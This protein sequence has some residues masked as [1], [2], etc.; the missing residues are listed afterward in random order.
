MSSIASTDI[1]SIVSDLIAS[2]ARRSYEH[3]DQGVAAVIAVEHDVRFFTPTLEAVLGQRVVPGTIVVADCTGGTTQPVRSSFSVRQSGLGPQGGDAVAR[4]DVQLV[5]TTGSRSFAD[6]LDRAMRYASLDEKVKALWLLHD[7]SRPVDDGCLERLVETWHNTPTASIL[8]T[9]QLDWSGRNLHNVGYYAGRHEL[10]SLVVEGEPDQEQYDMRN[11]VYAVSLAGA[12]VPLKTLSQIGGV[13]PWFGSMGEAGDLC[14][15][16]CLDGG[17]VVVVPR[18]AVAHRRARVEGLRSR[19]GKP[20]DE[21]NP[22][23]ATMERYKSATRFAYTDVAAPLWPLMWLVHLVTAVVGAVRELFAKHPYGAWCSLCM[24]WYLLSAV[25]PAL[26]ARSMVASHSKVPKSRLET[27]LADHAQISQWRRR[28]AAFESQRNAVLLSPLASWHLR[29]MSVKR[30][31]GALIMAVVAFACVVVMHWDVFKSVLFGASIYAQGLPPTAINYSG[32]FAS[33]TMPWAAGVGIGSAAPPTPWLLVWLVISTLT[34]GHTAAALSLLF[35]AAAPLSALAFWALAGV[36]TRSNWVRAVSGLLW[37]ALGLALGLYGR[38]DLPMLTVMIFMPAA[39]AFVFRAV[40]MY[41]TEDPVRPHPSVQM[42]ACAG[43]CFMPVVCAQPQLL[44][45]LVVVF[46]LFIVMVRSHRTMLLLIPVPAALAVAPTL[47]NAVHYASRGLWRQLF[48]DVTGS[49]SGEGYAP[50]SLNL[51]DVAARA[52]GLGDVSKPSTWLGA[53]PLTVTA[54]VAVVV[55][56]VVAVVSL[57]LPFALRASRMMWVV[58]VCGAL[59][60][61]VSVRVSVGNGVDGALAG[62]LMPGMVLMMMALL[63]C[64][65]QVAGGAVQRYT[66]L[67]LSDAAAMAAKGDA[68]RHAQPPSPEKPRKRKVRSPRAIAAHAG[69][70]VLVALLLVITMVWTA[71]GVVTRPQSVASS[72]EGLPMVAVDYLQR[73]PRYRV[74]ALRAQSDGKVDYTLMRSRRG[75]LADVSTALEAQRVSGVPSSSFD[76][77]LASDGAR[78][79]ANSDSEAVKEIGDLGIGGIYVVN[80]KSKAAKDASTALISNV[81]ASDGVQAVVDGDDGTYY[82]LENV[83]LDKQGVPAAGERHARTSPWRYAWLWCLAL[84]CVVY[85][86]VAIPRMRRYGREEA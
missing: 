36:F 66:P 27:L 4:V 1:Q 77:T 47:V 69:R 5:R 76:E 23:D 25:V 21:Q 62:S 61:L 15:R 86:L 65:C 38:A 34:V 7:D 11:D 8:G 13:N 64:V 63:S 50:A 55:L 14:R 85:C 33:A 79:L 28:R 71:S 51:G 6:A 60:A 26:K 82:Q 78:L 29:R 24:P 68:A 57:L 40:G 19:S 20:V 16:I 83:D 3:V 42:A 84:V 2:R 39:F 44:L 81:N 41:R 49:A 73:N 32:L 12:L 58:A 45:A 18:A 70:L 72:D 22:L 31:S 17:R 67:R 10:Q 56:L 52:F 53:R 9:K 74:L 80:D 54:A 48:A 46:V 30:W 75:D 37:V 35:F 43:L 59:L